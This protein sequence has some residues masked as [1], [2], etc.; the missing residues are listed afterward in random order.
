MWEKETG[1]ITVPG[2]SDKKV[3][4]TLISTEKMLGALPAPVE[5]YN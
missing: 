1:R 3:H 5:G 2:Q 4:G